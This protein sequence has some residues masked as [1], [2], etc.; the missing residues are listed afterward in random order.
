MDK[1]LEEL[2]KK[3]SNNSEPTT[4]QSPQLNPNN[5]F[6]VI[7]SSTSKLTCGPDSLEKEFAEYEGQISQD[8]WEKLTD[9]IEEKSPYFIHRKLTAFWNAM[10]QRF[11]RLSKVALQ[12][13]LLFYVF[14]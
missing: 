11:P 2:S 12:V 4:K 3:E 10:D 13:F 14:S 8:E 6:Q 5:D 9:H 1:E 7:T